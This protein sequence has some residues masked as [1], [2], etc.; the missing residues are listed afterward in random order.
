MGQI[1]F[2]PVVNRGVEEDLPAQNVGATSR[3]GCGNR[4]L[5]VPRAKA[6]GGGEHWC[7]DGVTKPVRGADGRN[8]TAK[9][10]PYRV[11]AFAFRG[12][13]SPEFHLIRKVAKSVWDVR[14]MN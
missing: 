5:N 1:S 8:A 3:E 9:E 4:A 2:D 13:K 7:Q 10:K 11:V 14:L 6:F 12:G